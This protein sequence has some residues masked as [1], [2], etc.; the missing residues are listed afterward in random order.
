M[1]FILWAITI[2]ISFFI[3]KKTLSIEPDFFD[4]EMF[5]FVLY[6]IFGVL[7]P[8][9]NLLT[10]IFILAYVGWVNSDL[11]VEDIAKKIFFIKDKD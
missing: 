3:T 7:F 10:S 8:F 5:Y 9:I 11:S 4:E 1:F 2:V 6:V